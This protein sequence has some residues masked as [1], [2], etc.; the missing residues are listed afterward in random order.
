M[1]VGTGPWH[2]STTCPP[3]DDLLENWTSTFWRSVAHRTINHADSSRLQQRQSTVVPSAPTFV[4]QSYRLDNTTALT[5]QPT[6]ILG[7]TSMG[8]SGS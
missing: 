1:L 7:R 5:S 2:S 4:Y 6:R 3:I 8:L